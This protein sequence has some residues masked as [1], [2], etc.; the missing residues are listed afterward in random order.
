MD[1]HVYRSVD[2]TGSIKMPEDMI[3]PRQELKLGQPA[4]YEGSVSPN[5][6]GTG[7]PMSLVQQ[8]KPNEVLQPTAPLRLS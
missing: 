8:K 5:E 2:P 7:T 6:R 3:K 4:N 1:S